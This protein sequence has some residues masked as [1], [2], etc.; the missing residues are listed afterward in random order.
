MISSIYFYLIKIIC[1]QNDMVTILNT[2]NVHTLMWFQVFLLNR[3]NFQRNLFNPRVLN[4]FSG[5]GHRSFG[6]EL[7]RKFFLV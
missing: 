4:L 3:N 6:T 2:D 5:T 1:L 7:Q